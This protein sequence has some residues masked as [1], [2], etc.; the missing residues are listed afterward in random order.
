MLDGMLAAGLRHLATGD[1]TE[2]A[3]ISKSIL[4]R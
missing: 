3:A 1:E 4:A 2:F